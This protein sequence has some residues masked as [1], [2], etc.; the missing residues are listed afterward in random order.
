[1]SKGFGP[2]GRPET[3]PERTALAWHRTALVYVGLGLLLLRE[4]IAT[5]TPLGV[6]AA[7]VQLACCG[8]LWWSIHACRDGR[9]VA[10]SGLAAAASGVGAMLVALA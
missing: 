1:M 7:V 10:L 3:Q 8:A 9:T 6:A 4:G 2:I 5:S